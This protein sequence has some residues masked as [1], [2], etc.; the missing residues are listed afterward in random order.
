MRV[1]TVYKL[2]PIILF[3]SGLTSG[4]YTSYSKNFVDSKWY[5]FNDDV[6]CEVRG[7]TYLLVINWAS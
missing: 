6:T 7:P 4:H 3:T 2:L 5:H 1:S